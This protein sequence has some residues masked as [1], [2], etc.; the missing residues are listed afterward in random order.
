MSTSWIR[1]GLGALLLA[2]LPVVDGLSFDN[3]AAASAALNMP[4]DDPVIT[5]LKPA[6]ADGRGYRL[7]YTIDAPIGATWDFKTDFDSQ[8]LLTNKLISSHRLVSRDGNVVITETVYHDKPRLKFKWQTRM[9][10]ERHL[11]E[12]VLLNPEECGQVYHRGSIQL[13]SVDSATRVTQEAYFD[14]FGVSI[15]VN[16]PFSGGMRQFLEYTA[17]W[18]QQAVRTYWNRAE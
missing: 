10:P 6:Q 15:W 4:N 11:L 13:D 2:A 5:R 1:R 18:E 16:Y 8:I 12:F 3:Q 9:F 7:V 14:F 17:R